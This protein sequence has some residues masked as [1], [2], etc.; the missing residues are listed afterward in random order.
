MYLLIS[1]DEQ[2]CLKYPG[3]WTILAIVGN[4]LVLGSQLADIKEDVKE[5]RSDMRDIN[6]RDIRQ[7][8]GETRTN[9]I[10]MRMQLARVAEHVNCINCIMAEKMLLK[11]DT[12]HR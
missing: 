8:M 1:S 5:M 12:N 11:K 6:M 3:G 2:A 7:D 9:I 4:A 10:W